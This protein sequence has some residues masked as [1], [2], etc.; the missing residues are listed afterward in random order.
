[1]ESA[2]STTSM[3]LGLI[4][5]QPAQLGPIAFNL[6]IQVVDSAPFEVL[7][8]RPFFDVTSCKEISRAGGH[9]EI[10]VYDPEYGTP[11]VFATQP[12][13]SKTQRNKPLNP[14]AAVKCL[15]VDGSAS[16]SI[17]AD[18]D[19]TAP[20]A[21]PL[22]DS[23]FVSGTSI[24]IESPTTITRAPP[25]STCIASFSIPSSP[26]PVDPP[27]ACP[28]AQPS[29]VTAVLDNGVSN[30]TSPLSLE[31]C[32]AKNSP[33]STPK[34]PLHPLSTPPPSVVTRSSPS[35][36]VTG[37]I[38][39]GSTLSTPPSSSLALLSRF[40][41]KDPAPSFRPQGF[42]Q[43][44]ARAAPQLPKFL[45]LSR[46]RKEAP[47]DPHIAPAAITTP[48]KVEQEALN[49]D[50]PVAVEL[51][52][53]D[54]P[55]G[56]TPPH[57]PVNDI[58]MTDLPATNNPTQDCPLADVSARAQKSIEGYLSAPPTPFTSA[59]P[60]RDKSLPR[61]NQHGVL[62]ERPDPPPPFFIYA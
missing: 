32:A 33:R 41:P 26:V 62:G 47:S 51:V 24:N 14:E 10:R 4:E 40:R 39:R 56:S 31:S 50:T 57:I 60:P 36:A 59:D 61:F 15:F 35:I 53:E 21:A 44:L 2:N 20:P 29:P 28:V 55:S 25:P 38:S 23:F 12:R 42:F 11:Y 43:S 17:L 22:S 30:L 27:L 3:T 16:A 18:D 49:D 37:G 13:L 1:M 6:Q 5:D 58:V 54:T 48:E 19:P 45:S 34:S 9:H 46:P 52:Q 7:L 8:G